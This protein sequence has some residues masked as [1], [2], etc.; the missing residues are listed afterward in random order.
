MYLKKWIALIITAV[1]M[2]LLAVPVVAAPAS[3]SVTA[4]PVP[5]MPMMTDKNGN[6]VA[7]IIYNAAGEEI[8]SILPD[9]LKVTSLAGGADV[10]SEIL[11]VLT[12]A[13]EQ[14]QSVKS[15]DELVPNLGSVLDQLAP[16]VAVQDL[17]IKDLFD[18]SISP[19]AAALLAAGGTVEFQFE[20]G[21]EPDEQMLVLHN[22]KGTDWEVIDPEHVI[23]RGDG[24]LSVQF[25][26]LSPIAFVS[27]PGA[28]SVDPENPEHKSP[29]TSDD[30][31]WPWVAGAVVFGVVTL[32][33]IRKRAQSR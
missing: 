6:A 18:I 3:P 27:V 30:T 19:E 13:Y 7:G 12:A 22:L 28:V 20:L 33:G 17:I 25:G 10:D 8:G 11:K 5:V 1:L 16:G 26:S 31:A 15:L 9:D 32:F 23:N 4:K 24:T 21:I 2:A 14:L 29:Q